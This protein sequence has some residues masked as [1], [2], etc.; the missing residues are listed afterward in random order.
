MTDTGDFNYAPTVKLF[1]KPIPEFPPV[2]S[3]TLPARFGTSSA[4]HLGFGGQTSESMPRVLL[5]VDIMTP[6]RL[7]LVELVL[8]ET[9]DA[10]RVAG[11]GAYLYPPW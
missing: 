11:G 1:H 3:I 10:W 4:V 8:E 5:I 7:D 6:K 9:T 2:T